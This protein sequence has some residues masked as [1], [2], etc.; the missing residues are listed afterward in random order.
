MQIFNYKFKKAAIQDLIGIVE[1]LNGYSPQT[2]AKYYGLIHE[3]AKALTS[4][5]MA[6]PLVRDERLRALGIRWTFANNYM[7]FFSVDEK[8]SL[9]LI[10]R[11]R[12]ARMEHDTII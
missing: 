4:F 10:E 9:V 1:H 11:I 2:A 8:N 5:P 6:R 12:F 3:K 7:I